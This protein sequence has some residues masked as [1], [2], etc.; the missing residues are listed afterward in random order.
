MQTSEG[1]SVIMFGLKEVKQGRG[2]YTKRYSQ[3]KSF[4][5]TGGVWIITV[6]IVR[7]APKRTRQDLVLIF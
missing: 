2:R 5:H 4:I 6:L 3:L 7:S 1:S